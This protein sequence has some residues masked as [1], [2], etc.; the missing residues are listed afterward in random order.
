ML[1]CLKMYIDCSSRGSSNPTSDAT[2]ASSG[3]AGE[4]VEERVEVVERVADLVDRQ[5]LGLLQRAVRGERVLLEEEPNL[6][7]GV[8]E[9]VVGRAG[10]LVR[11]EHRDRLGLEGLE[12]L[13]GTVDERATRRRVGEPFDDQHPVPLEVVA[14]LCVESH[15]HSW[16]SFAYAGRMM[17]RS[18]RRRSSSEQNADWMPV[19]CTA[20]M[21]LQPNWF[22]D[23]NGM[24]LARD[25]HATHEPVV[26]VDR[27]PHPEPVEQ[28]DRVVSE[29]RHGTDLHIARRRELERDL[30]VAHVGCQRPELASLEVDVDQPALGHTA[31]ER[32]VLDEAHAVTD[33]LRAAHERVGD[34]GEA[35]RLTGMDGQVGQSGAGDRN[36]V[37]VV[38]RWEPRLGARE[39]ERD[40]GVIVAPA[41]HA[42]LGDLDRARLGAHRADD[43]AH[44][45]RTCGRGGFAFAVSKAGLHRVDDGVE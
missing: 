10:L 8:E 42:Q 12:Q 39:I 44:D 2:S 9:V 43:R 32:H 5:L 24:H 29:C 31:R 25:A 30:A 38:T 18:M 23:G 7:A 11:R 33:P 28:R 21:S 26:S 3:V 13:M 4:V 22:T 41:A 36:R 14:L 20:S 37:R 6:V 35:G 27:R 17:S 15:R 34:Q 16:S 19:T 45:D 1:G 40:D